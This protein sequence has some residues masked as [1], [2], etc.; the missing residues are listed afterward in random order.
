MYIWMAIFTCRYI[1]TICEWFNSIESYE[2]NIYIAFVKMGYKKIENKFG[3]KNI[4]ISS[5]IFWYL[6]CSRCQY[7]PISIKY[8]NSTI[9]LY[10]DLFISSQNPVDSE[11]RGIFR[12]PWGEKSYF[13]DPVFA[14]VA[15]PDLLCFAWLDVQP[16]IHAIHP[17]LII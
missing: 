7:P 9:F 1:Q 6:L 13:N 8:W 14:A 4:H 12:N 3:K 17:I 15:S 16:Y 5:W 11:Q 10:C 2:P